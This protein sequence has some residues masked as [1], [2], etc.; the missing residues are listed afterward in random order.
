VILQDQSDPLA[1]G[2]YVTKRFFAGL[3]LASEMSD[4]GKQFFAQEFF[5]A[6]S[7]S[8]IFSLRTSDTS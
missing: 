6:T 4:F 7:F 8:K 3:C 1:M 5:V 2:A